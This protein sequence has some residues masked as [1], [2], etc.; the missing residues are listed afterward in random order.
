MT[1]ILVAGA[2]HGGLVAAARLA[3]SG[4]DVT[5]FEKN[6]LEEL[7]HDWEDRFTF[8]LL[9]RLVG[10]DEYP[11][12]WLRARGDCAFV[13][14][15][16]RKKVIIR[17]DEKTRQR[18]AWR[19]PALRLLLDYAKKCG[20]KF[21]EKTEVLAP[22]VE[23]NAVVGLKTSQG[24]VKA[25]LVID[26]A[27]VFSPVRSNLPEAFGI[28][29]TPKY[30]DVFYA[31]R[32][33]FDK[34]EGKE[35][36]DVPFEV[37]LYHEGEKGLS[38][39]LIADDCVDILIGRIYP[40]TDEKIKEQVDLFRKNHPCT[41][42]RILHGGQRGVIP[43]R[44][45]LTRLV[46]RGYAAVGDSAFVTTPMNGMGIDL[47]LQAGE[48]LASAILSVGNTSVETLWA[49]NRAYHEKC[50]EIA[51]NEGLKNALLSMP[52]EGVDFLF[53]SEVIQSS[54]LSGAGRNT[55]LSALLGKFVRGMKKPKYFFTLLKGLIK[56]GQ[57]AKLYRNPPKTF[58]E[59]KIAVWNDKIAKKDIRLG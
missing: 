49:Y 12:E 51:K 39:H 14:P 20:V 52:K 43:V 41:G 55:K 57:A 46:A 54:D 50:Y 29:R 40:L 13:S 10:M 33:Y 32:A 53:E 35:E 15:S 11:K 6:A 23:G 4:M 59:Q 3:K 24:D 8:D 31:Y 47:S 58:D 17:Y 56:G 44:R 5:L 37:F 27:G 26:A 22:L 48:M 45:P 1:K 25:D 21:V 34:I 36:T 16:H 18:M 9:A 19:K 42:E 2:G 38:W 7:G 28:E 30:G